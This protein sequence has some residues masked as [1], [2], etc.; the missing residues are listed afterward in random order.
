MPRARPLTPEDRRATLVAAARQV[1]A[2]RGYHGAA[3]ADIIDRAG[4]ARGTFY[5]HF[6]SKRAV[7]QAVLEDVMEHVTRAV[8]PID[9][10]RP[11]APQVRAMIRAIVAAAT[12][13]G[14]VRLLFTEAVGIDAE[15]DA[16][17]RGFYDAAAARLERALET[18]VR[19]GVVADTDLRLSSRCLIG[20]L[21]EPLF[22]AGLRG[23]ALDPDALTEVLL[24]LLSQG[25]LRP[26]G[27]R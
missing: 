21:K 3:I 12:E 14:V 15:G 25:V 26:V 6:E 24:G 20:L 4:V 18:G 2:E 11:I 22:Q 1:F 16:A 27:A 5:N 7:L 17:I 19:L 8:E 10:G 13:P 9:V 23:E